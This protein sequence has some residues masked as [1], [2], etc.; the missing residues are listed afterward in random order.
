MPV[1]LTSFGQFLPYVFIFLVAG[2][3]WD[4]VIRAFRGWL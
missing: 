4:H 1:L 2:L 3:I